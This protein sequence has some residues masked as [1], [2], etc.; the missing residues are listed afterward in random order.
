MDI[1]INSDIPI[2][3]GILTCQNAELAFERSR[4]NESNKGYEVGLAA[5]DLLK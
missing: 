5:L 1:S 2:L 3:F 4:N